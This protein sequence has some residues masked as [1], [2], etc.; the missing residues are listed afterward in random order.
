MPC[1]CC[2][3]F[4]NDIV[5]H[6]DK[7]PLSLFERFD[8]GGRDDRPRG[9]GQEGGALRG[10][11]VNGLQGITGSMGGQ[12][13]RCPHPSSAYEGNGGLFHVGAGT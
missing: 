10:T 13:N 7:N 4:S 8:Q 12:G 9:G 3:D 5:G 6:G 11:S 2:I 1:A